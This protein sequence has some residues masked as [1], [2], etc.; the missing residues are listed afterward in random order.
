VLTV[1]YIEQFHDYLIA[2]GKS[3]NT[4][5][6]YLSDLK[7]FSIWLQETYGEEG[8]F[9]PSSLTQRDVVQYRSYLYTTLQRKPAGINRSL[10]SVSAFC[11]WARKKKYIVENPVEEVPIVQQVAAPPKALNHL[12]YSRL[13]RTV[14]T[15]GSKRDIAI[16]GLM[17]DAGL[18]I[19]EVESLNLEDIEISD[20]KGLVRIRQGKGLKYREV[21]LNKDLRKALQSYINI[22]PNIDTPAL[23]ISQWKDRLS[24]NSI[25]KLVKKY[26]EASGLENLTPHSLRHSFGTRLVRDK[27]NDIV[28][29]AQLMGHSNIQTT[30]IYTKASQQDLEDAVEKLGR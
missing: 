6:A 13:M 14:E 10:R 12:E 20:R 11:E 19:G 24:S 7:Q 27:G 30:S 26:G 9:T 28:A 4:I 16:I 21:P 5:K 17:L 22:R 23:F 1:N 15:S 29:V 18:R 8:S 3:A 25:W 2:S